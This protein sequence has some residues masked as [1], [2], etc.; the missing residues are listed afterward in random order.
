MRRPRV[1]LADD[2][3]LM[4]DGIRSMLADKVDLVGTAKDGR[5][6]LASALDL[7]PDIVLLDI[8]MPLLNGVDAAR[9]IRKEL[10]T[11]RIVFLTMHAERD[12]VV[13]AFKAGAHGFLLKWSAQEE[14]VAAIRQV[15]AGHTYITPLIPKTVLESLRSS[16]RR[17]LKPSGDLS[18]RER[19][20]L[21]LVAEGRAAKEIAGILHVSVKTAEYHKYRLM[22]KLGLHSTAELT[23]YAVQRGLV[24][25]GT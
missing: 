10:P 23:R 2:H 16:P 21:Q 13:E 11:T 17:E 7:K 6:L 9:Q 25:L 18:A 19:E 8:S 14:L 12:Y 1:L 22:R 15:M 24:G 20:V 5:S 3:T 4:L